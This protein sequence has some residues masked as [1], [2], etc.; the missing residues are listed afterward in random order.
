MI[1]LFAAQVCYNWCVCVCVFERLR[2]VNVSSSFFNLIVIMC[3]IEVG[4][5]PRLIYCILEFDY[6]SVHKICKYH[7]ESKN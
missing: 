5:C 2:N 6:N 3:I 1:N 7:S 4:L